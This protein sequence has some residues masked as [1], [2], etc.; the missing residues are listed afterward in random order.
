METTKKGES[1][2]RK[3]WVQEGL[4]QICEEDGKVVHII[5]YNHV[6]INIWG[7]K[8]GVSYV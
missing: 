3:R 4:L 1:K 8:Q 2:G 5:V 7:Q 6:Y